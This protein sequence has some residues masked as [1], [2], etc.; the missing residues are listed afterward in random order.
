[1]GGQERRA[2]KDKLQEKNVAIFN[3]ALENKPCRL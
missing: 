3:R 2:E 1:M